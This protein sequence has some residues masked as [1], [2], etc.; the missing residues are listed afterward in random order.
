M[1]YQ[2]RIKDTMSD[3]P[4]SGLFDTLE[5]AEK[6][7]EEVRAEIKQTWATPDTSAAYIFENLS[8]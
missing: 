8:K 5:E 1:K 7:L 6:R 4:A 3:K 2:V